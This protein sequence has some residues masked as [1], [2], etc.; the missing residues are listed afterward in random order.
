MDVEEEEMIRT[1][2]EQPTP[3]IA[4]VAVAAAAAA[5]MTETMTELLLRGMVMPPEN[6]AGL[7]TEAMDLVAPLP[8]SVDSCLFSSHYYSSVG[9]NT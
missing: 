8:I 7:V 2:A 5:I 6:A 9:N 3:A 1:T 4:A